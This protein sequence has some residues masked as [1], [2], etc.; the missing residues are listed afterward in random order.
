[1]ITE[2]YSLYQLNTNQFYI[3]FTENINDEIFEV[4]SKSAA[5]G[6]LD[7]IDMLH[8]LALRHDYTGESAENILFDLFSGKIQG[9]IGIDREIQIASLELYETACNTKEK[10]NEDTRKF[11]FPSKLLYMAGSTMTSITQKQDISTTFSER[12]RAQSQLE[13]LEDLDLWS[14]ARML[15]TDEINATMHNVI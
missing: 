15:M 13:Q 8:N 4:L 9:K 2:D 10:I 5:D 1:M 14:N 12:V 11:C 6:N 7:C 3:L